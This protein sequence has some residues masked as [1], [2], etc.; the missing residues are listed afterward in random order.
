MSPIIVEISYITLPKFMTP[1]TA[2]K[3]GRSGTLVGTKKI[4]KNFRLPEYLWPASEI[5][6]RSDL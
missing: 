5:S 4:N 6:H 2:H 3:A 1:I